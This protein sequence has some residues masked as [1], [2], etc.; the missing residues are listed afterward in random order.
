MLIL[1]KAKFM[2]WV[3]KAESLFSRLSKNKQ[4]NKQNDLKLFLFVKT[5]ISAIS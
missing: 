2:Y 4:I 1:F 5:P 3:T